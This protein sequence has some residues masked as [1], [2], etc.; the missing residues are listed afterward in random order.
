MVYDQ[1]TYDRFTEFMDVQMVDPL[2]AVT[3]T[4][5]LIEKITPVAP[6]TYSVRYNKIRDMGL[7]SVSKGTPQAG[8]ARDNVQ[9]DPTVLGL[10]IFYKGYV[11]PKS[12][13]DAFAAGTN[14][15]LETTDMISA[16]QRV[17]EREDEVMINGWS[18]NG[19]TYEAPGM[20]Q[21]A[22]ANGAISG[23]SFGTFGGAKDSVKVGAAAVTTAKVKGCNYNLIV[24]QAEYWKL[25]GSI[26]TLGVPELPIVKEILNSVQKGAAPGDVYWS[27]Y[28]P[29]G[30]GLMA[31]ADPTGLH[32]DLVVAQDYKNTA[33][34]DSTMGELSPIYG[35][36]FCIEA[37][38]FKH[39]ESVIAL[40]GLA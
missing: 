19:S 1:S 15:T 16:A 11:A 35:T 18:P 30:Y 3:M 25:L 20:Y 8:M 7:A 21:Q 13:C 27:Y 39:V 34:F 22:V 12:E 33:G 10:N 9:V 31:P 24:N 14:T 5:K 26:S 29:A 36:T 32:L 2:R 40:T 17:A 6:G 37:L 38:R 28:I 23:S 4:R